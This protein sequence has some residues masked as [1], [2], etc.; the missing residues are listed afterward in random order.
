MKY[1]MGDLISI[2][3]GKYVVIET[4]NYEN[5]NYVFVNKIINDDITNEFYIL[6]LKENGNVSIVVEDKLKNILMSKFEK[7]LQ[8]EIIELLGE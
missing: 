8:K 6:E 4:L 1:V 3:T 2:E 5:K 7:I